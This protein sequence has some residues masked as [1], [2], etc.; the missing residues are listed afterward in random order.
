[1]GTLEPKELERRL[2]ALLKKRCLAPIS[3]FGASVY[4]VSPFSQE[5]LPNGQEE[6]SCDAS[7][8]DFRGGSR[9]QGSRFLGRGRRLMPPERLEVRAAP[10]GGVAV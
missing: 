6:L 9:Y 1:M 3:Y 10:G 4:V 5:S 2:S 8:L 7:I